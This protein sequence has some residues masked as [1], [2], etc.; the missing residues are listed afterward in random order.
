MKNI[1]YRTSNGVHLALSNLWYR[2]E[3]SIAEVED[4]VANSKTG[5]ELMN[6]LNNLKLFEKFI[7]D[8]ETD[9]RVRLKSV[10]GFGNVHYFEA[11]KE[12][13]VA[14]EKQLAGQITDAL[15]GRFSKKDF[16]DAM[17]REHRTLQE[18]FTELCVWWFEQLAEMHKRGNY[19][20]R[21]KYSCELGRDIT[22]FINGK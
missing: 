22:E 16:C 1:T 6:K 13:D 7:V 20:L 9:A 10:D 14:K 15:N 3:C 17:S 8:R 19:D 21:N 11:T 5:L 12:I 4:A 2:N 18:E